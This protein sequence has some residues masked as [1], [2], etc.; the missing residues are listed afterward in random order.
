MTIITTK[1]QQ[2]G[3]ETQLKKFHKT[4]TSLKQQST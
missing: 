2:I 3:G 1:K 4:L